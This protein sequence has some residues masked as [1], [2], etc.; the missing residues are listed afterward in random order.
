DR[1]HDEQPEAS[2]E[3]APPSEPVAERRAGEQQHGE[4][5]VIGVYGPFQR[6]DRGGEIQP[7]RA[8]RGGDDQRVERDPERRHRSPRPYPRFWLPFR[9]CPASSAPRSKMAGSGAGGGCDPL[10]RRSSRLRRI[11]R[12]KGFAKKNLFRPNPSAGLERLGLADD[13]ERP[14]KTWKGAD[15]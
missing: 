5:Q 9:S 8:Q 4:A 10:C 15:R 11:G 14:G 13:M 3:Y 12:A 6:L 7:D 1:G 2:R